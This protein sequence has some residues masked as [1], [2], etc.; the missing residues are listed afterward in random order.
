MVKEAQEVV[1]KR[2]QK[3]VF[4]CARKEE[5]YGRGESNNQ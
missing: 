4:F 2:L 3:L 1:V 5:G